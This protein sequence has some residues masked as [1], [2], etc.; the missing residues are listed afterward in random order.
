MK[1]FHS[2]ERNSVFFFQTSRL[3]LGLASLLIFSPCFS[4]LAN[5]FDFFAKFSQAQAMEQRQIRYYPSKPAAVVVEVRGEARYRR[6][7]GIGFRNLVPGLSLYEGDV[8]FV[9]EE[10]RVLLEQ[11]SSLV[12][13]LLS[14]PALTTHRVSKQ[15]RF[16]TLMPR[17]LLSNPEDLDFELRNSK[18]TVVQE[19]VQLSELLSGLFDLSSVPT[20][21][22]AN[23][24]SLGNPPEQASA[25]RVSSFRILPLIAPQRDVFLHQ[26][27]EVSSARK[28]NSDKKTVTSD[29]LFE[30]GRSLET[31]IFVNIWR[32]APKME[33]LNMEILEK[34]QTEFRWT[35]PGTGDFALQFIS[36]DATYRSRLVRIYVAPP[37]GQSIVPLPNLIR[38]GDLVIVPA[39]TRF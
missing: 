10:S 19:D 14:L 22:P 25:L 11:S 28:K 27:R 17:R 35:P 39:R 30:L 12:R 23:E 29:V 36:E 3:I 16:S 2:L 31:H 15:V 38:P 1:K 21:R 8:V 33:R 18:A 26:R 4:V 24:A 32:E 7:Q 13:S 5:R 37:T 20:N 9:E 6:A 34:G